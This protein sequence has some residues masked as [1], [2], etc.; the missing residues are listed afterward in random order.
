[1]QGLKEK[2]ANAHFCWVQ[3]IKK[4]KNKQEPRILLITAYRMCLIR[5]S[6]QQFSVSLLSG[7]H[8]CLGDSNESEFTE[9]IELIFHRLINFLPAFFVWP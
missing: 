4:E 5:K 3:K 7:F 6:G 2:S 8:C 1:M 9:V